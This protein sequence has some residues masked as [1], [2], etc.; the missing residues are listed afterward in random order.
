M[1]I[2]ISQFAKI[3]KSNQ[4]RDVWPA[5]ERPSG[6]RL[7]FPPQMRFS[8]IP[9]KEA[10]HGDRFVRIRWARSTRQPHLR[11]SPA[12]FSATQW[13]PLASNR[14]YA[15]VCHALGPWPNIM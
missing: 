13:M 11:P 2:D 3:P 7:F 12:A 15:G 10:A 5:S 14:E 6:D 9:H 4:Q 8:R 1:Q